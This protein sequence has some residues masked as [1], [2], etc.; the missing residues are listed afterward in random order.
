MTDY[1]PILRD[2][3]L[4]RAEEEEEE[5]RKEKST[6]ASFKFDSIFSPASAS[7][8]GHS[9]VSQIPPLLLGLCVSRT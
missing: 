5:E 8:T 1:N 2:L 7:T 3:R 9:P 4:R 6:T